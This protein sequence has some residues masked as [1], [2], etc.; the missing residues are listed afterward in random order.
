ME[1]GF[2]GEPIKRKHRKVIVTAV[3]HRKLSFE[4][5]K[6]IEFVSRIK[7]F[8][9]FAMGTFDLA[10]VPRCKRT[11]QLVVNATLFEGALKQCG[12]AAAEAVGKLKAVVGL[13]AFNLE[14][15]RFNQRF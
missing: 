14:R 10:V 13:N 2:R 11:N 3:M 1:N 7:V 5:V 9:V 4:I 15:K 8:V 6:R 12:A